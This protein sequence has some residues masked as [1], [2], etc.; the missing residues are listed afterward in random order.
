[1]SILKRFATSYLG[2]RC[3]FEMV[4]N[5]RPLLGYGAWTDSELYVSLFTDFNDVTGMIDL[6]FVAELVHHEMF[7][8]LIQ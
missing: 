6:N 3:V 5:D 1:M 2:V 7:A 4:C 8:F